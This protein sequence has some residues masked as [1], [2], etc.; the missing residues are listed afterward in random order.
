MA[1][2]SKSRKRRARAARMAARAAARERATS[3]KSK[4]D[5]Y[6]GREAL[7]RIKE[8]NAEANRLR[9]L[10]IDPSDY[11]ASQIPTADQE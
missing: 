6:A 5:S 10:G 11:F 4:L 3:W 2:G 9:L 8:I 1:W 7:Q